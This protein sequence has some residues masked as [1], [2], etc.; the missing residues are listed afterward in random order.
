MLLT[1]D[2][3]LR[4]VKESKYTTP[5]QVAK[6]FETTTTIASAALG[7][8][9]SDSS[10][11]STHLKYGSSPYYYDPQQREC[12]IKIA[13]SYFSGSELELFEKIKKEQIVSMNALTIPQR[14]II[15]KLQ[16]IYYTI[17]ISKQDKAYTF[18]IWY[19]RDEK[20][21][22]QQIQDAFSPSNQ[23]SNAP[24]T[25]L[26]SQSEKKSGSNSNKAVSEPSNQHRAINSSNNNSNNST[27][28]NQVNPFS[29]L[30]SRQS[31]ES[32]TPNNGHNSN[33]NVRNQNTQE[34]NNNKFNSSTKSN[35]TNSSHNELKTQSTSTQFGA[36]R[37]LYENAHT[38]IE[39]EKH[40]L[41]T[42]YKTSIQIQSLTLYF[43]CL[44][45]EHKKVQPHEIISF[46][47]SSLKP[48]IIFYTNL[49]KKIEQLIEE[50]ENC[51]LIK[52]QSNTN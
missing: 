9:T 43:D 37:Y 18:Y 29:N 46:Y 38:I 32:H 24:S 2:N 25:T 19:L 50:L 36:D 26:P 31:Q 34:A 16:D 52:T 28:Q 30:Y 8:L 12:L 42:K 51:F 4:F 23:S 27:S 40:Q 35:S 17:E 47:T 44:S 6:E 10:L 3:L 45:I 20:T 21:T 7:E 22:R 14:S 48:K 39:K 33:I 15:S 41:G 11:L 49:P 1:K 5:T 13:Q